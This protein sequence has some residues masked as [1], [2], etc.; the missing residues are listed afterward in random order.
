MA[1]INKKSKALW[2][3]RFQP[4]HLGHLHILKN[5]LANYSSVIIVIGSAQED[6]TTRNPLTAK[7]RERMIKNVMNSIGAKEH[8][9]KLVVTDDIPTNSLWAQYIVKKNRN[10]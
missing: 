10:L 6:Y 3:G 5:I 4:F 1:K 9:Y 8:H 7:E 2:I